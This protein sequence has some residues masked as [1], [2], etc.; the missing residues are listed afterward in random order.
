MA[1]SQSS[2][3]FLVSEGSSG[4]T[5]GGEQRFLVSVMMWIALLVLLVAL[6]SNMVSKL[7]SL[8]A[9]AKLL[10]R[11]SASPGQF[12]FSRLV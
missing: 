2:Q 6:F 7:Y 10:G 8:V 1:S 12:C 9:R 4:A 5:K 3:H 11:S